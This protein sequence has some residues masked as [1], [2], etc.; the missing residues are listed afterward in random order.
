MMAEL[1]QE[2][3]EFE[4]LCEAGS[5]PP[6]LS[7][8]RSSQTGGLPCIFTH[9]RPVGLAFCLHHP[10]VRGVSLYIKQREKVQQK[11]K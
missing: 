3:P 9:L 8:E 4:H 1:S 11:T 2:E 7:P 6:T 5:S 10:T